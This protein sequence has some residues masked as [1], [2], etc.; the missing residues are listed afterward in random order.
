MCKIKANRPSM[1]TIVTYMGLNERQY[2]L[3]LSN[4]K[5]H[6]RKR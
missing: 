4:A 6:N 5:D 3:P 2:R 1:P